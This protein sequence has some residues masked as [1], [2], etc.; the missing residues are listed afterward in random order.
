M[1]KVWL[2]FL[3][4]LWSLAAV[5]VS[6]IVWDPFTGEGSRIAALIILGLWFVGVV[7]IGAAIPDTDN[8]PQPPA[9]Q[10]TPRLHKRRR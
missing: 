6:Q 5:V 9:D 7:L 8:S 2:V 4:C 3:F 10:G 1:K